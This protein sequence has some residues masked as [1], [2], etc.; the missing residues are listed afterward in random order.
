ML[1]RIA[2]C[3]SVGNSII[4]AGEI[5]RFG[6]IIPLPYIASVDHLPYQSKKAFSAPHADSLKFLCF[7]GLV[8]RL[9]CLGH[10]PS[11]D[12]QKFLLSLGAVRFAVGGYPCHQPD[13][14]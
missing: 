14:E 13:V 11:C 4:P 3:E 5:C 7:V 1:G 2:R 12:E 6:E 8:E 9:A 10:L